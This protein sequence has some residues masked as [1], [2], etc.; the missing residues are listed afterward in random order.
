MPGIAS[1]QLRELNG[2]LAVSEDIYN[3]DVFQPRQVRRTCGHQQCA[4]ICGPKVGHQARIVAGLGLA[5]RS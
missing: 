2:I 5:L 1:F 3:V 4:P